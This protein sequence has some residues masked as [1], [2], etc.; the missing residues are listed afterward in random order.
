MRRRVWDCAGGSNVCRRRSAQRG[1]RSLDTFHAGDPEI[2]VTGIATTVMPTFDVLKPAA[3]EPIAAI[4][5]TIF[6]QR[7]H[8]TAIAHLRKVVDGLRR[9]FR[10]AAGLLGRRP[11]TSSR[12][13]GL[14][15]STSASCTARTCSSGSTNRSS[16]GRTSSASFRRRSG[17]CADRR[18]AAGQGEEWSIA[19]RRYFRVESIRSPPRRPCRR[20]PRSSW[21]GSRSG[22]VWARVG[23]ALWLSKQ[24]ET[25]LCPSTAAAASRL[26]V[27]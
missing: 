2:V 14:P 3:A 19:Q 1:A 4:V 18:V 27:N 15:V 26:L 17:P 5:R 21:Q 22:S 7:D 13:A 23:T 25:T 10:K 12:I 24:R 20:A 16:R 6:A 9:G 11:R 8:A